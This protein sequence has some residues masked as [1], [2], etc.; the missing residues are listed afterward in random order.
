MKKKRGK[1]EV[2]SGNLKKEIGGKRGNGKRK[3]SK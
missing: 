1:G 3:L 2:E